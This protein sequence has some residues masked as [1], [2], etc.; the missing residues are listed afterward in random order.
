[1]VV[2]KISKL[3]KIPFN[4]IGLFSLNDNAWWT[5]KGLHDEIL[6]QLNTEKQTTLVLVA[7]GAYSCTLIQKIWHKNKNHILLDIGSTLDP[8]LFGKYTRQYHKRLNK[9]F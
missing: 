4:F 8:Y 5:A 6:E 2:N 1:M 9:C 3:S 7:G